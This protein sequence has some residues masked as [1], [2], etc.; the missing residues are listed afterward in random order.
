MSER[1]LGIGLFVSIVLNV[2]LAAAFV[3]ALGL[4]GYVARHPA[5]PAMRQAAG[6]LDGPHRAAFIAMLREQGQAV[7][8]L[9]RQAH[10]LRLGVWRAMQ[11]PGFDPAAAK[12]GL[13]Q[14]RAQSTAA[15]AGVE[16]AF[17]DFAATLPVDQRAALGRALEHA[18]PRSR[19]ARRRGPPPAA[20][21]PA[22]SS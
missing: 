3:G 4:A 2:F 20:P 5:A 7:R 12:T 13:A 9:N 22:A 18:A 14:A 8:P 21:E 6:S 11:G 15:R 1:T 10:A 19:N 16:N 17:V